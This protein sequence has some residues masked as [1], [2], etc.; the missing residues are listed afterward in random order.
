MA[1]ARI[2]SRAM[3][4]IETG[5]L[6]YDWNTGAPAA[7]RLE[8][9]EIVWDIE[10]AA[11]YAEEA[12]AIGARPSDFPDTPRPLQIPGSPP[13]C[14]TTYLPEVCC[15]LVPLPA[16]EAVAGLLTESAAAA[17][18]RYYI[19]WRATDSTPGTTLLDKGSAGWRRRHLLLQQ[20]RVAGL[21][22]FVVMRPESFHFGLPADAAAGDAIWILKATPS[23]RTGDHTRYMN[24]GRRLAT[25][26]LDPWSGL[27]DRAPLPGSDWAPAGCGTGTTHAY[28]IHLSP[29]NIP[30]ARDLLALRIGEGAAGFGEGAAGFVQVYPEGVSRPFG[31]EASENSRKIR[32]GSALTDLLYFR[33]RAWNF[34]LRPADARA[35]GLTRSGLE[36]FQMF[37]DFRIGVDLDGLG[38]GE[39][40]VAGIAEAGGLAPC[41]ICEIWAQGSPGRASADAT[42]MRK[43]RLVITYNKLHQTLQRGVLPVKNSLVLRA[44][45][46][47]PEKHCCVCAFCFYAV[48]TLQ[49]QTNSQ[50]KVVI[51]PM[52]PLGSSVG[53]LIRDPDFTVAEA[54]AEAGHHP[55]VSGRVDFERE[56]LIRTGGAVVAGPGTWNSVRDYFSDPR[57]V[58]HVL[59]GGGGPVED[60]YRVARVVPF[61][62][63]V[64]GAEDD[65]SDDEE[66]EITCISRHAGDLGAESGSVSE[67][68]DTDSDEDDSDEDDPDD[69]W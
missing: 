32:S 58:G 67:E 35:I 40:F 48:G 30:R 53:A 56:D 37:F 50:T 4:N 55:V 49:G 7:R 44:L 43:P 59:G 57:L 10:A 65:G 3:L 22:G 28:T 21:T 46:G 18:A 11:E 68:Y 24:V 29:P 39:E 60:T 31:C 51:G 45:V 2:L 34:R 20:S 9:P 16:L 14:E 61:L 15:L 6:L 63:L 27:V 47:R 5:R 19:P 12:A 64:G 1:L 38:L 23:F 13:G 42:P 41:A 69:S 36:S 66:A 17:P 25:L 8:C 52:G 62:P 33:Y 54:L 26:A